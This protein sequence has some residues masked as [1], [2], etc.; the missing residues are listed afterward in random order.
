MF[1]S[2][3]PESI[4]FFIVRN[5]LPLNAK[6]KTQSINPSIISYFMTGISQPQDAFSLPLAQVAQPGVVISNAWPQSRTEEGATLRAIE[7]VLERFP[8]FEAYQTVDVPFAT[9]RRA[10]R[11]LLGEQGRPHTY[12]LTR[13]LGE[14]KLSLSSLDAANRHQA[15][16]AVVGQFTHAE[17][18]GARTVAVI[19]GPRPAQPEQ[20]GLALEALEDSLAQLAVAIAR[21]PTLELLIEPLDFEAD[22]RNTLGTT[23]EAVAICR[24]L[25][26]NQLRLALCLDTAHLILNG[27]DVPEAVAHA[28][29][30]VTE[31][32]FCNPV[33]DRTSPLYGDRH[34][35][36]GPPGVVD[37]A[38]ISRLLGALAR[39]GY[40]STSA[41]PRVYCEVMQYSPMASLDVIGH[42]QEA[43][44]TAWASCVRE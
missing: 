34:I 22:K 31:F 9:E 20:R 19:S 24:R 27:E 2:L 11:R 38:E 28:R 13:V 33:L 41:R 32:H 4:S 42:C 25:K 3:F 15:V 30:F 39:S 7:Q 1:S 40:L 14:R 29:D 36:F 10:I 18:I 12:T 43:L 17:E 21:H 16:A 6:A 37:S 35:P 8:W 23:A 5:R 26:A 44:L